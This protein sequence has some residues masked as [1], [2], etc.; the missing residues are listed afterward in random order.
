MDIKKNYTRKIDR[1]RKKLAF[2]NA[3]TSIVDGKQDIAMNIADL[4]VAND[5]LVMQLFDL[6]QAKLDNLTPDEFDELLTKANEAKSPL[7]QK[8]S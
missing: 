3:K 6:T 4:D 1:E 7:T 2:S 5:Y 8:T